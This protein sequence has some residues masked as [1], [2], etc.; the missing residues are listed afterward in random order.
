MVL[1]ADYDRSGYVWPGVVGAHSDI[2]VLFP[3]GSLWPLELIKSM[4]V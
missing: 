1:S 4:C 3:Q 2:D